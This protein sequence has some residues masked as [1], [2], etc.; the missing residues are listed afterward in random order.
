MEPYLGNEGYGNACVGLD[1]LQK[2]LGPNFSEQVLNKLC[3]KRIPHDHVFVI[4]QD[5]LK[6]RHNTWTKLI[7]DT[8]EESK[9]LINMHHLLISLC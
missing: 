6:S 7:M 1:E 2:H 5:L 8:W 9:I 3:N 4:L